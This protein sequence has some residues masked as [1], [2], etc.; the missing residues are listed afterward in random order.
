MVFGQL[1][2]VEG[3]R[4]DMRR[5]QWI[6]SPAEE[7]DVFAIRA[8]LPYRQ[9][10]DLRR[11]DPAVAIG[12]TG[13]GANTYDFPLV[14]KAFLKLNLR[15]ISGYPSSADIML[16]I[17]RREVDGRAGSWSSLK[18]FVERGLVR[19]L[20]RTR[21]DN[22]ELRAIPVDQ[23][24]V[25]EAVAKSVLR[26]R[27]I[28]NRLGRPF[29]APPGA[30]AEMV[31]AYRDAFRRMTQDREFVAEAER[32]GVEVSFTSPEEIARILEEVFSTPAGT[33]RVFKEFFRF[34]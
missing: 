31:R 34:E 24:L 19:P 8:D 16:A 10:L 17:E 3:L 1:L 12:A 14:L 9:I 21:S 25:T 32:A 11:A 30:P 6:G 20:V 7:T 18:P 5:W 2:G 28:P 13:P 27:A 4:V 26:L 15:I 29:V 23:D 33:V 22:P